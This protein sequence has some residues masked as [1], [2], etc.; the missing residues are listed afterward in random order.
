MIDYIRVYENDG[1]GVVDPPSNINWNFDASTG[2]YWAMGCDFV[3]NDLTNAKIPG[4][5]CSSRCR[6][7]SGCTHFTWT[8]YQGGTCWMKSGFVTTANAITSDPSAV[9]G[10]L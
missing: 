4:E 5:Q 3:G 8:S 1:S 7:T 6:Q 2:S 10:L 9:C